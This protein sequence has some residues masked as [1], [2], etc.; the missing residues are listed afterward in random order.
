M[1]AFSCFLFYIFSLIVFLVV[2]MSI[3][4]SGRR[5]E[6]RKTALVVF[7]FCRGDTRHSYFGSGAVL[8]KNNG[9]EM[10]SFPLAFLQKH[11]TIRGAQ[12]HSVTNRG[13]SNGKTRCKKAKFNNTTQRDSAQWL[14]SPAELKCVAAGKYDLLFC[15][16][17]Q[18]DIFIS[19]FSQSVWAWCQAFNSIQH[20]QS[21]AWRVFRLS[22][23]V[24]IA[25]W[26]EHFYKKWQ[27]RT[28][29]GGFPSGVIIT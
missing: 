5:E 1:I 8:Y 17:R 13:G 26:S 9:A 24:A 18:G 16:C 3:K 23:I 15:G 21:Y 12:W 4:G 6:E 20:T 27:M 22:W 11:T 14:F 29:P 10:I 19:F 2:C 25:T 28:E 7:L